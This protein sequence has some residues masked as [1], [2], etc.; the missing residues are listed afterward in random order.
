MKNDAF[1]ADEGNRA[2]L[3][4]MLENGRADPG[5]IARIVNGTVLIRADIYRDASG[6]FIQSP[7]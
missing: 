7:C 4:R 6:P 5:V 1:F 3:E 2:A